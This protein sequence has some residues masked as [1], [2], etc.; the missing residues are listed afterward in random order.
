MIEIA[1]ENRST[2]SR[3]GKS[4]PSIG[5]HEIIQIMSCAA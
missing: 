1:R 2:L 5:P 4:R 3:S